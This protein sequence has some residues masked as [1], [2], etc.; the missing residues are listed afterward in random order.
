[1]SEK[2]L[3]SKVCCKPDFVNIL[4]EVGLLVSQENLKAESF[5][6]GNNLIL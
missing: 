5:E 4:F 3:R 6:T 2:L 1:M